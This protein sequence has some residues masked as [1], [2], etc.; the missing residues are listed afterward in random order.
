MEGARVAGGVVQRAEAALA[1]GCEMV[2]V[3]NAPQAVAEVLDG[4][5]AGP[6][7]RVRAERM[8]GRGASKP[9]G[10]DKR[11]ASAVAAIQGVSVLN[12]K[13]TH[14][15]D[16]GAHHRRYVGRAFAL[17]IGLNLAFVLVETVYG[18]LAHSMALLADAGHNLS[19]VLALTLAWGASTLARR[20]PSE[21]FTYGL[22]SSSI[23]VALLNAAL[24]LVVTGGIAWEA[25]NRLAAPKPVAGETVIWV[26][27]VG[28]LING[29]SAMLFAR[30]RRH[31]INMRGAFL[32]LAADA[33]VSFGVV[34]AGI[35]ILFT[36]WL[37]LDP[38]A[39]LAIAVA[40]V[41]S[42]WG[43]LRDSV[44][45]AL[46]AVPEHIDP[47]VVR[48]YLSRL[49]GVAEV[50]DLH[51]CAMSTTATALTMHLVIPGGHPGDGFM[52][53][54]C[55]E[56]RARY[57]VHH[58]TIQIETGAHPCELAPDHVV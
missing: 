28:I 51:H 33:A 26:A 7:D 40:I 50:H 46:N 1:A 16:H 34:V 42:T 6:L 14:D 56:L 29:A 44:A 17:G 49:A 37:W 25:V 19:D 11:Y 47:R 13:V 24:L 31:D 12:S 27:L 2:L 43:L 41:W 8:R 21:R 52:A 18:V 48:T 45:L 4:L 9:L 22:R 57:H 38:L 35:G 10:S 15:H 30:D 5:T 53:D 39:G 36:G 3:C 55:K 54:V 32:H 23:L 58:A 20:G